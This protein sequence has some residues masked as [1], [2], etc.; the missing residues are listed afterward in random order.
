[1]LDLTHTPPDEQQAPP[2]LPPTPSDAVATPAGIPIRLIEGHTVHMRY[3]MAS[4]RVLE[5]RFGS[6]QG[7]QSAIKAAQDGME[8][9]GRG[10]VM[11]V[12]SD[13]VAAGLL[14]VKVRNPDTGQVVRLGADTDLVM[15]QLDPGRLQ[16]YVTGFAQALGAAFGTDGEE[17]GKAVS[18]AMDLSTS[19]GSTGTTSPSSSPAAPTGNSGA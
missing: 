7:I 10:P 4:L 16:E 6:L 3:S 12:L 5:A 9:G 1:M 13:A 2:P 14:H 15:E 18:Q 11:T 8:T 17:A 19:P